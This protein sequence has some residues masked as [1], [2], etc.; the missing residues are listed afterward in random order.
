MPHQKNDW[1]IAAYDNYGT[2]THEKRGEIIF[3]SRKGINRQRRG[4]A[5]NLQAIDLSGMEHGSVDD[6]PEKAIPCFL[7]AADLID[8]V[9]G[10]PGHKVY[11]HCGHGNSRTAFALITFLVRHGGF[12]WDDATTFVTAGQHERLDIN[13]QLNTSGPNGSYLEW[14]GA[15]ERRIKDRAESHTDTRSWL[16]QESGRMVYLVA[17]KAPKKRKVPEPGEIPELD[18]LQRSVEE[19]AKKK[20]RLAPRRTQTELLVAD[21]VAFLGDNWATYRGRF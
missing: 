14:L 10:A 18:E 9:L 7:A 15:A 16:N 13:F 11:L 19:P 8:R 21:T 2:L 1:T 20:R 3:G 5:G 6:S 17:A 12:S 4:G